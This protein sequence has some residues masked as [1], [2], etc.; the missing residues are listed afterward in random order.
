MS[1]DVMTD[2]I[3]L[4]PAQIRTEKLALQAGEAAAKKVGDAL[5]QHYDILTVEQVAEIKEK[6]HRLAF[7]A[8]KRAREQGE[9][10]DLYSC[11]PGLRAIITEEG[12]DH[13]LGIFAGQASLSQYSE[14]ITVMNDDEGLYELRLE[15]GT[16]FVAFNDGECVLHGLAT[17]AGSSIDKVY[18]PFTIPREYVRQI[19]GDNGEVWR[20]I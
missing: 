14:G 8:L 13:L 3:T 9:V 18:D 7:E 19:D 4:T 15:Q 11:A 10:F 1:I 12:C 2:T 5:K 16:Y 17:M 6:E 20:N